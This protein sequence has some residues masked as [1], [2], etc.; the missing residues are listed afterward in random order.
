MASRGKDRAPRG[1]RPVEK[2]PGQAS[3]AGQ[4]GQVNQA[5]QAGQAGQAAKMR[6]PG[7]AGPSALLDARGV[8][9]IGA[10][11]LVA[12]VLAAGYVLA[13]PTAVEKQ[14]TGH[15]NRMRAVCE[16]ALRPDVRNAAFGL[17]EPGTVMAPDFK[18][19]DWAGREVHL[20]DLRGRVVLVN[21]W[22]T[23]CPPCVAEVPS[24]ERLALLQK[25]KDFTLLAVS[26]DEDWAT[27]RRFF[28][29]GSPLTVLLDSEKTI[30]PLYGTEKF[31]ESFII[32]R[33]GKI[34]FYVVSDRD[35]STPA[36]RSCIDAILE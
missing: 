22:F 35:W 30:P 2:Q 13:L 1:E 31:P 7:Q 14:R 17:V 6:Q 15:L 27:V 18:L 36:V 9:A 16:E 19:K 8:L 24:L 28:T 34:L 3:Q 11:A 12:L 10:A 33:D 29:Q 26:V 25:N 20:S 23:N 4:A 32:D 21:F 5:G